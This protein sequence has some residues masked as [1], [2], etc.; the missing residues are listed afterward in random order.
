MATRVTVIGPDGAELTGLPDKASLTLQP[1]TVV[2]VE[3]AGGG[4]YGDPAGRSAEARR[5]DERNGR[6]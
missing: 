5:Y 1:G 3:T 4:G 2:R 6:L